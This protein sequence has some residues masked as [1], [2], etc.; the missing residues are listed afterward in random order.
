MLC[1]KKVVSGHGS[2]HHSTSNDLGELATHGLLAVEGAGR[3][4]RYRLA[5]PDG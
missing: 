4:T 2:A 3:A 1:C 5:G